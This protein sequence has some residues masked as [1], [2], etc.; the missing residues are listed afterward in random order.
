MQLIKSSTSSQ[1]LPFLLLIPSTKIFPLFPYKQSHSYN[2]G[3][4][5]IQ[6][7]RSVKVINLFYLLCVDDDTGSVCSEG[8]AQFSCSVNKCHLFSFFFLKLM[9]FPAITL[10]FKSLDLFLP[11]NF[12]QESYRWQCMSC[13]RCVFSFPVTRGLLFGA[14]QFS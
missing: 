1:T 9:T 8:K 14:S 5:Y 4:H 10:T 11:L 2:Y 7:S 6:L 13:L 3:M 12:S